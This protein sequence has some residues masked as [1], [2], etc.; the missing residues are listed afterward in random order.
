MNLLR[1]FIPM[2]LLMACQTNKSWLAEDQRPL[3]WMGQIYSSEK[4][5]WISSE[6]MLADLRTADI[7]LLGERHDHPDHWRLQLEITQALQNQNRL[8]LVFEHFAR[9]QQKIL[10][11]LRKEKVGVENWA[12]RLQWGKSGWPA[13]ERFTPLMTYAVEHEIDIV[14]ANLSRADVKNLFQG[15]LKAVF[16]EE[17]LNRYRFTSQTLSQEN[18]QSLR[19]QIEESHC[20]PMQEPMLS[21]MVRVQRGR[22]LALAE[23]IVQAVQEHKRVI[24][25]AGSGH[26]RKDWGVPELL[27]RLEKN[28]QVRSV[29]MVQA[30]DDWPAFQAQGLP[31]DYVWLTPAV[32]L[33]DPCEVYRQ[34]LQKFK[35]K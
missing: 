13:W 29:A 23:G 21:S 6:A 3:P 16:R 20:H 34:Q 35:Q 31:Y 24:L 5:D 25:F 11:S 27:A 8:A 28:W 10:E 33:R 22:D 15:D 4:G 7:V 9:D 14:A 12:E 18:L 2:M 17:E 30:P 19:A 26:V 1:I 32:D